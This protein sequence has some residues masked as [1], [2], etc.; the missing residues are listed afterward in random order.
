MAAQYVRTFIPSLVFGMSMYYSD[1]RSSGFATNNKSIICLNST[2]I[3]I[4]NP[5]ALSIRICNPVTSQSF[6]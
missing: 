6:V 2:F 1:P 3:G 5:D 4:C